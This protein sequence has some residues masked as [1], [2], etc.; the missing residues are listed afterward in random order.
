MSVVLGSP[1]RHPATARLSVLACPAAVCPHLEF[2]VS[3]LLGAPVAL[4]WTPQ[5]AREGALTAVAE[6]SGTPGL[7]GR[8]AGRLRSLG[9]VH[10]EVQED[11]GSGPAGADAERYSYTPGLGLFRATLAASGDVVV[12]ESRLRE[13]LAASRRRPA[14]ADTLAHEVER[15]LG[16]AWDEEL[17]PLRRGGDG[18]PVSWLRRTG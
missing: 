14:G 12:T 15:L 6:V 1:A 16:T 13:L 4:R 8:I 5:P 18:A 9:P 2:A 11:A 17:E 3:A 7:A 10:F